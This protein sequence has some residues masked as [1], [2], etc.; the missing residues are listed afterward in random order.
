M[1]AARLRAAAIALALFAGCGVAAAEPVAVE[2]EVVGVSLVGEPL[3]VKVAVTAETLGEATEL[4]FGV[5]DRWKA[6]IP[7]V[8]GEQEVLLEVPG[9]TAGWHE[10]VVE[11]PGGRAS[12]RALLIPGVLSILPPLVAIG[13]ALVFRDVLVSLFVGVLSGAFIMT[14]GDPFAAFARSIDHFVVSSLADADH[15]AII[16]FSTLLG[17][18]VGIIT[19]AAARWASSRRWPATRPTRVAVRSRPGSWAF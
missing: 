3:R 16:I 5:D 1:T 11:G 18:M 6:A 12:V 13:L 8:A 19:A 9:L 17:G 2:L 15:A 10:V 7:V 4:V 14:G